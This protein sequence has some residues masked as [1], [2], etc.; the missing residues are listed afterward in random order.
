MVRFLPFPLNGYHTA[1]RN[2]WL[3]SSFFSVDEKLL[4]GDTMHVLMRKYGIGQLVDELIEEGYEQLVVLGAGFDHLCT[5]HSKQGIKCVEIDAPRM[6][7]LKSSFI[8]NNQFDNDRLTIVPAY[9]GR[10]QLTFVLDVLTDLDPTRKTIVVAEGFFDYL[11][12]ELTRQT[13]IELSQYFSG[14]VALLSTVFS[15]EELH[16]AR[17]LVYRSA[18]M[19]VG[20]KLRLNHSLTEFTSLLMEHSFSVFRHVSASTMKS[21][22]LMPLGVALPVLPGFYLLKAVYNPS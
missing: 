21:R 10:D 12:P 5:L 4:P 17:A 3:R 2:S 19:M 20:E 13:L 8:I 14:K 6:A 18:V 7:D 16:W 15:L 9:F 1:F 11:S 22:Y